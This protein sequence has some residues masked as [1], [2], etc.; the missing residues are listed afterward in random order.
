MLDAL[1][2]LSSRLRKQNV[3]L[4]LMIEW[5]GLGSKGL[6]S[7]WAISVDQKWLEIIADEQRVS[8]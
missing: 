5:L 8:K 1:R 4:T 2:V 7:C 3:L 6:L